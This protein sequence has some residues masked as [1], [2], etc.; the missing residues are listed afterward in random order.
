MSNYLTTKKT[1][2]NYWQTKLLIKKLSSSYGLTRE[3]SRYLD[4]DSVKT[5]LELGGYPGYYSIVLGKYFRA[6]PTL[7]D[8]YIDKKVIKQLASANEYNIN[9]ITLL[10]GDLFRLKL[11]KKYD[12]VC[13]F[14][15]IEHF[16]NLDEV[17]QAHWKLVKKNGWMF[18]ALPNLLGLNGY[19][20]KQFDPNNYS[21]HNLTAMDPQNIRAIISKFRVRPRKLNTYYHGTLGIWLENLSE[22]S[23]LLKIL[24][25]TVSLLGKLLAYTNINHRLISPYLIITAKK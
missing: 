12:F 25:Y 3:I 9:D 6:Q 22:R 17:I 21:I 11:K 13:S 10:K 24:I 18:I 16:Y 8:F 14:G 7:L 4:R 15:L 20:Q 5:T 19:I 2:E 23:I 1:W